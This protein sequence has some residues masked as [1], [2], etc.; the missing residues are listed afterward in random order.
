[1]L[2]K[3]QKKALEAVAHNYTK[4]DP[5][6]VLKQIFYTENYIYATDT[7]SAYRLNNEENTISLTVTPGAYPTRC[8]DSMIDWYHENDSFLQEFKPE[9]VTTLDGMKICKIGQDYYDWKLVSR[10]VRIL[11]KNLLPYQRNRRYKPL[12]LKSE[13]G[14]GII[15]PLRIY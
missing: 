12:Y 13:K 10:A 2:T 6:D 7:F 11:G 14:E 8:I 1:M 9:P 3:G 5:R 15:L 4:N